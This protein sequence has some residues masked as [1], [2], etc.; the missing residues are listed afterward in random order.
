VPYVRVQEKMSSSSLS[1]WTAAAAVH[2]Q[3]STEP[4]R[5][6]MSG[7]SLIVTQLL[8][9]EFVYYSIFG[10]AVFADVF[11]H[12]IGGDVNSRWLSFLDSFSHCSSWAIDD[13]DLSVGSRVAGTILSKYGSGLV[14]SLLLGVTPAFLQTNTSIAFAGALLL[15][16]SNTYLAR[17][18]RSRHGPWRMLFVCL[19]ALY[20]SR[21]LGFAVSKCENSFAKSV[22][23]GILSVELTGWLVVAS[24]NHLHGE[25]S[26]MALVGFIHQ[27]RLRFLFTFTAVVATYLNWHP[28]VL[29]LT[30]GLHK[31]STPNESGSSLRYE[32][33]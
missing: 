18:V 10:A 25:H 12:G 7:L 23:L 29:L 22:L 20:K 28:L 2:E 1:D 3:T 26:V 4:P 19:G 24:R 11:T 8:D 16:H 27:Y 9:N 13:L 33:Y 6:S 31:A 5:R 32:F 30:L 14:T 17:L 21:K 15:A